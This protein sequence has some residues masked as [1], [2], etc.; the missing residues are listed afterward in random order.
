ML[1]LVLL[2][3]C[4]PRLTEH[5]EFAQQ[6]EKEGYRGSLLVFDEDANRYWTHNKARVDSAFLP[7]STFKIFNS[8]AALESGVAADEKL[9][10]PW[11][12]T[13]RSIATWNQDL[14][15]ASA[16]QYSCVPYYQEIARR[17][18]REKMQEYLIREG[19]G[20]AVM[21]DEIHMFWLDASLKISQMEQIDFL[22]KLRHDELKFSARN[23][24]IV[25]TIMLT[26]STDDYVIR[27]KTGWGFVEGRN[28]GWWVGWV[29]KGGK[30]CYFALNIFSDNPG[31]EFSA[32]RKR[33]VKGALKELGWGDN[34]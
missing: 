33:I 6:F 17:V 5:K 1:L 20:N 13:V 27:S 8:M 2:A 16:I 19:Y 4:S 14:D 22:R 29:E 30:N 31:P 24:S 18:G 34:F 15:M 32:A 3:G 26:D 7:A 28:Y 25:R 9:V 23:Q 21:G 10:I 11:D 12:S